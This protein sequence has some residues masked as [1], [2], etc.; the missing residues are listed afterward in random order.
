MIFSLTKQGK[1]YC[2]PNSASYQFLWKPKQNAQPTH[3]HIK[4]S[5]TVCS[6]FAEAYFQEVLQIISSGPLIHM[7]QSVQPSLILSL[8]KLNEGSSTDTTPNFSC[9]HKGQQYPDHAPQW[10]QNASAKGI[11]L[12][13]NQSGSLPG[14]FLQQRPQ[15]WSYNLIECKNRQQPLLSTNNTHLLME[16]K[17]MKKPHLAIHHKSPQD[18]ALLEFLTVTPGDVVSWTVRPN[19]PVSL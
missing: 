3:F 9:H 6:I 2:K 14:L 12:I 19:C 17:E 4:K 5:I 15:W 18:C 11:K 13:I 16:D 1:K 7:C 10:Q 8:N